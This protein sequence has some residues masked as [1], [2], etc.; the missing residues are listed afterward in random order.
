VH[1]FCKFINER[2]SYLLCIVQGYAQAA[3]ILTFTETIAGCTFFCLFSFTQPKFILPQ[4]AI[5]ARALSKCSPWSKPNSQDAKIPESGTNA[6]IEPFV[7]LLGCIY[8]IMLMSG[9]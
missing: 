3:N 1:S 2:F 7:P 5:C 6:I 9:V 8:A 4:A